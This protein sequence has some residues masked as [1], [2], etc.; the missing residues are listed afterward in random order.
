MLN[1]HPNTILYTTGLELNPLELNTL[2][3]YL[4]DL[5]KM[6]QT[7]SC[8]NVFEDEFRPWPH[9]YK[10]KGRSKKFYAG[11]D[12]NL[13]MDLQQMRLSP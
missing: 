3:E 2:Y 13:K 6:L 1:A 5:G 4:Y 11:V 8:L 10:N 12:A 7:E 9:L